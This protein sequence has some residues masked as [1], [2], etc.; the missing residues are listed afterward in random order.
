MKPSRTVPIAYILPDW[1]R[2]PVLPIG[3]GNEIR[4]LFPAWLFS[5]LLVAIGPWLGDPLGPVAI[6]LGYGLG[7]AA[8]GSIAAGH[9]FMHRTLGITLSLPVSRERLWLTRMST[10]GAGMIPL[11]AL[12]VMQGLQI[13]RMRASDVTLEAAVVFTAPILS[14]LFVA[15]WVT[16]LCRSPLAGTVFTVCLPFVFWMLGELAAMALSPFDPDAT[17]DSQRLKAVAFGLMLIAH[18]AAGGILSWRRFMRLEA[19]EGRVGELRLP[20]RLSRRRSAAAAVARTAKPGHPLW[21]LAKKEMRLQQIAFVTAGLYLVIC[22][23][24]WM[25]HRLRPALDD[26]FA[27]IGTFLYVGSVSILIGSVASAEERQLGTVEWQ[28]L[29]PL[30]ARKQWAVKV[31]IVLVLG[32]LLAALLPAFMLYLTSWG[33]LLPDGVM[34]MAI[35]FAGFSTGLAIMSL[36]FS[37]LC[38]NGLKAMLISVPTGAGLLALMGFARHYYNDLEGALHARREY[39]LLHSGMGGPGSW[40]CF[41]TW[42]PVI[43]L[44]GL[45]LLTLRFALAN[46]CSA[47]RGPGRIW[48]QLGWLFAYAAVSTGVYYDLVF[49][50]GSD[51]SNT[52]IREI[53]YQAEVRTPS[54]TSTPTRIP[55]G[56]NAEMM[57]RY[58]LIPPKAVLRTTN[59][60][61]NSMAETA[62]SAAT[63]RIA[64]GMSAEMMRRYGLIPPA[65]TSK[66]APAG[67]PK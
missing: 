55:S 41:V 18:W 3:V 51:P 61:D 22:A 46:H 34:A 17:V 30:A 66:A 9:D 38:N 2:A 43:L 14:G 1:M 48:R 37:S 59:L 64:S 16:L 40:D 6:M 5:F 49:V 11:G 65:A 21:R 25:V 13:S 28:V 24:L 15:P 31:G 62:P 35:P 27:A 8:L 56:I 44:G 26:S 10:A 29:L 58:G 50:D 12:A 23:C 52:R 54:P 4:A 19:I 53:K 60:E 39:Y 33:D 67:S 7:C 47:E 20:E 63:N 42:A 57:R 45:W 36:Y 32:A